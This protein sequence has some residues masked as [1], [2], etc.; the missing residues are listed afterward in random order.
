MIATGT[1][2]ET[3]TIQTVA[4]FEE[5]LQHQPE[6][7]DK[8]FEFLDG[9]IIEK[10]G[11]K[12]EE[13]L[14]ISFLCRLFTKTKSYSE[15][16][17]LLP[18][19]D[20]YINDKRKRIPDLAYFT[21]QQVVEAYQQ[22]KRA[23]TLFAIELLSDN[24]SLAEIEEKVED[25]FSAGAQLVWYIS[26][27]R[28]LI[29]AFTASNEVKILKGTDICSAAPVLLDFSFLVSDLFAVPSL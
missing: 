26:I 29:Y 24:E 10:V 16:A 21:R 18:E 23:S 22:K 11:M 2:I 9:E 20:S 7:A 17:E 1:R 28:Q 19:S 15:G 8:R 5:W 14:A 6:L 12:Q 4:E 25:Y 3:Y 13:F 27:K